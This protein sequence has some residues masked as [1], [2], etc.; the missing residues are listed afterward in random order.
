MVERRQSDISQFIFTMQR[1]QMRDATTEDISALVEYCLALDLVT[2]LRNVQDIADSQ[3]APLYITFPF[4]EP[5]DWHLVQKTLPCTVEFSSTEACLA[6]PDAIDDTPLP[7]ANPLYTDP[8]LP[9]PR[10]YR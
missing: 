3:E 6:F 4:P 8:I 10:S 9:S 2:S 7:K 1:P 5:A